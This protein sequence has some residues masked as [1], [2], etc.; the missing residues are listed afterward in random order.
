MSKIKTKLFDL[1]NC[2]LPQAIEKVSQL[3]C[4]NSCNYVVTP[5]IDHLSRLVDSKHREL[6]LPIYKNA[7]L[8]LVDSRIFE[9]LLKFRGYNVTE[10]I[11]G[12]TLTLELFDNQM[13]FTDKIMI[14]GAS[15][16]VITRV[17][18]KYKHLDI[19]HYNPPM[20]FINST[21]EV[22]KTLTEI[23]R[24]KPNY[25]FLA[26]G[27]PRQELLAQ[28]IQESNVM[29]GVILC[30]GASILFL[31]G[32]EKRAPNVFQNL[33]LEWLYRLLQNPK[34]LMKRYFG[35]FLTLP[36]IFKAI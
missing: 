15:G 11:P 24:V 34:R 17:R 25:L 32:E 35:N 30:V 13:T 6:L 7:A 2:T 29:T 36:R 19:A 18:Q 8:N 22:D 21:N 5:N 23:E 16:S 33:H 20:G 12:S 26:V 10:V 31:V 14:V 1:D 3:S 4:C 28:R 27:S 9:K